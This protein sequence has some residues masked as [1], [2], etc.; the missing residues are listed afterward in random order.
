MTASI[1]LHIKFGLAS[2]RKTGN[3]GEEGRENGTEIWRGMLKNIE[4]S[5]LFNVRF[6]KQLTFSRPPRYDRFDT[7]P[8]EI[9]QAAAIAAA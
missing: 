8:Y 4:K 1:P 3:R 5:K 9:F 6:Q 2:P 7:A